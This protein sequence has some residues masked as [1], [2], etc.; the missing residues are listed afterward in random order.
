MAKRGDRLPYERLTKA[1]ARVPL[2][3][4]LHPWTN[5]KKTD[6]R[7]LPINTDI[8]M[9]E[10]APLPLDLLY[11]MIEESSHR[12]LFDY[13]GCRRGFKCKHYPEEIGCLLLGDSA[14]EA[15]KKV[16]HLAT[17]E[18][19]K[20]HTRR[21]AEA[22]L[23]PIVGK[24]RVDNWIFK[25]PDKG[26][27]VTVCYCCECCCVTRFART[28][29]AGYLDNL[30]PALEGLRVEVNANCTGCGLC[31]KKCYMGAITIEDEKAVLGPLCRSCGRCASVCKKDAIDII[32]EDADFLEKTRERIRSYVK[33]D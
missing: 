31:A 9:P 2:L 12:A 17:V 22:G 20:E 5:P 3:K 13:C 8:R 15:S 11:K 10:N 23:V 16:S 32:I 29:P 21:A 18:E 28:I 19:A 33:Y 24:A 25:I 1:I 7:W 30:F 4:P 27:M 6:M 26:T 14:L